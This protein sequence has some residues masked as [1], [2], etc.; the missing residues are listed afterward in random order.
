MSKAASYRKKLSEQPAIT[1]ELEL[2]SG[3]IFTVRRPPLDV[4]IA[5]GRIPQSFVKHLLDAQGKPGGT[6]DLTPDET[7]DALKF[8]REAILYAVVDPKLKIGATEDDETAIDPSELD[9][10]DFEFLAQW[11]MQGSPGVP[12]A[13]KGGAASVSSLETFRQKKPG[14]GFVEPGTDGQQVREAAEPIAA[15]A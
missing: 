8:T 1:T 5:S 7:L 11:I 2:P 12:V 10:A 9:P 14:G 13:T 15:T 6:L 4:W 3:A